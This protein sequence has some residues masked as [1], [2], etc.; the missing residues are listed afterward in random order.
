[1]FYAL[2]ADLILLVHLGFILFVVLG[3]LAVTRRVWLAWLHL[4][5]VAW[6]VA[7]EVMGWYCP[8]TPLENH[9][10]HLAGKADYQGDFIQ[11]YLLAAI[12]PECLAREVQITLGLIALGLNIVIYGWLIRTWRGS[13]QAAQKR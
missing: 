13:A 2:L 7:V 4:P 6:G 12:Y 8:L 9:F 1:M 11:H 10:R 3:G 5:C